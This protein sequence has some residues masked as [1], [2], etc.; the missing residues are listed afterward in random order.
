MTFDAFLHAAHPHI[1]IAAAQAVLALVAEGA[2]L[3]FIARYRKE[4]TQNLAER[5][6]MAVA[7]AKE[8]YDALLLRQRFVCE[9][10]AR[11][12]KLTPALRAEVEATFDRDAL[13]DLYVPFKRKRRTPAVAAA[14]AGLGP[15][16]DWI[17]NC[18]HGLDTPLPGQTLDLWAFTFRSEEHGIAD[19]AQAI[20][21]AEDILV[22][23][24]AEIVP[25]RTRVREA[26]AREAWLHVSRGERGK[27]G[28]RFAAYFDVHEP[29]G[30][31]LDPANAQR[32]LAIRRGVN[33]GEL[34]VELGGASDD[35]DLTARLRALVEA[36]ACTV[37]DAPGADV[38]GRA[39]RRAFDAHVL[40]AAETAVQKAL[41][42]A[43][44]DIAVDEIAAGARALLMAAPFG[45]RVVIGID[46]APR[47]GSKVAVVGGN[48][49]PIGQGV[50][51]AGDAEKRARAGDLLA[52]LVTAHG[53][54]AIAI[55]DGLASK[56][57]VRGVRAL[58]RER[59]AGVP[60]LVVSEIGAGAWAASE[61]GHAD[62]PDLDQAT[63]AAVTI[64]RRLQDPLA[65]LVRLE[66]RQLAVGMHVHDVSQPRLERG[67]D[68]TVAAC[69]AD[70]GVDVNTAPEH[71]LA[72]VP[73]LTPGLAR[74]I[75]E[76]RGAQ[77]PFASRAAVRAVPL[78]D[79]RAFEQAAGFLRVHGGPHALD[80]TGIHPERYETLERLAVT[81]GTDAAG[82][83]G[84]GAKLVAA[85]AAELEP[86]IGPYTFADVVRALEQAGR[87]PRGALAPADF[88][89]AVRTL[90]E[91]TPG[92]TCP[93][94][95]TS[96]TTFGAFVDIGLAQDGL[97]HVSR[98]ADQF[99][100]D[101]HAVVKPGDRVEVRVVGV[102]RD[103]QQIALSMRREAPAAPASRPAPS[104]SAPR[105]PQEPP[106]RGGDRPKPR[107][108]RPAFNN[109]FA[110]LA[111]QLRGGGG[112]S[113]DPSKG[114]SS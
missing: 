111:S 77:G 66:P 102:D 16:A 37:A 78:L 5:D 61:A 104:V 13:E 64:A 89:P 75:V 28:G 7:D 40:P 81:H 26:L 18:G 8:R 30:A 67:L 6:V 9:E 82:L 52:E 90:D 31:M 54:Q 69:V 68:A 103:K 108:P 53:A 94:I 56:D 87:D 1:P 11:Q 43:A 10:I 107:E 19:A 57:V 2:T 85:A 72:R 38:L 114:R 51:H 109:P 76:Q 63:R 39:A 95:V 34:R 41:R 46:L 98:L 86:E 25:L 12:G 23:R 99:V 59:G 20:A 79:H 47:G 106:R 65:E 45:P 88:A 105:R 93:G 91:L 32:Y 29:V 33:E 48:G 3:P 70:V 96:V 14:E 73:G 42:A 112:K 92:L 21:G 97:V 74:A 110:D 4:R 101:P 35:A 50:I 15:L 60:V 27:E 55:G 24:I 22:E 58:V 71:L 62:L 44:D 84:D 49:R 17:W 113:S 80:A 100:K 83:C 36:E